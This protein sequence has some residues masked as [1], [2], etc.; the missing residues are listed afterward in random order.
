MSLYSSITFLLVFSRLF[1]ISRSDKFCGRWI[2]SV[3]LSALWLCLSGYRVSLWVSGTW[4]C[5]LRPFFGGCLL[6]A[7]EP[8]LSVI[9][10]RRERERGRGAEDGGKGHG[11]EASM[12]YPV[13]CALRELAEAAVAVGPFI[14]PHPLFPV[15]VSLSTALPAGSSCQSANCIHH[16]SCTSPLTCK[17][18]S[19]RFHP[20][21]LLLALDG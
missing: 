10:I 21:D 6:R 2:W 4:S 16:H 12:G 3:N 14:P 18:A 1:F 13:V 19:P 11:G 7:C 9:V 8:L 15:C 20:F 17:E 5:G